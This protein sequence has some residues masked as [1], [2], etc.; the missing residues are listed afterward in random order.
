MDNININLDEE[1]K[2]KEKILKNKKIIDYIIIV[3]VACI[4]CIPLI[5]SK[6]D[7]YADDGIQ[8]IARAYRNFRKYKTRWIMSKYY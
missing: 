1:L 8:H 6:L 5:N 7:V 2:V 3:I 4:L